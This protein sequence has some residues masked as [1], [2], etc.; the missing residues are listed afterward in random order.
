MVHFYE[1]G[2]ITNCYYDLACATKKCGIAKKLITFHQ[3]NPI[4]MT[5]SD[6]IIMS[7]TAHSPGDLI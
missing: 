3:K 2:L 4:D 6:V 7:K 5:F 1:T